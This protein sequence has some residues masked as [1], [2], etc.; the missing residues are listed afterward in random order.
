MSCAHIFYYSNYC[1]NS[2]RVLSTISTKSNLKNIHFICID[3]RVRTPEGEIKIVL[4]NGYQMILPSE[5]KE[6]P[7]VLVMDGSNK[8]IKGDDILEYLVPSY[9][10][11]ER[12]E[13]STKQGGG[14]HQAQQ[15]PLDDPDPFSIMNRLN[16]ITSDFYSY[17]D[18]NSEE[19][20]AEGTGGLRQMHHYAL[21]SN[22]NLQPIS[23][24]EDDYKPDKIGEVS[25]EKIQRERASDLSQ[26]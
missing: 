19:L 18:Q 21:S 7:A 2:K 22:E 6:V 13:N 10:I 4:E 12:K 17:L 8:I 24:P 20:S 23:T 11:L 25:M 9:D 3:R 26:S 1:E 15:K 16:G 5:I 14:S